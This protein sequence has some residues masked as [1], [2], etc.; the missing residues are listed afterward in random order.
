MDNETQQMFVALNKQLADVV[1]LI[2]QLSLRSEQTLL[3]VRELVDAVVPPTPDD[4]R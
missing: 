3:K 4:L 1:E 2:R